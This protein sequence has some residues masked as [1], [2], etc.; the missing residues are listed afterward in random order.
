M[1]Q[2]A[3]VGSSCYNSSLSAC[4]FSEIREDE[5][6]S[7]AHHNVHPAH[8]QGKPSCTMGAMAIVI[9][10]VSFFASRSVSELESHH[11]YMESLG[12]VRLAVATAPA[13]NSEKNGCI[14][15]T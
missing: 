13:C 2:D 6:I 11:F 8:V 7:K 1:I 9:L 15:S 10:W 14:Y 4:N 12:C 3:I 5:S